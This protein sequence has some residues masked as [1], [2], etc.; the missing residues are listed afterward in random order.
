M[1][2]MSAVLISLSIPVSNALAAGVAPEGG[3]SGFL[4]ECLIGLL[5]LIVLFQF[6]PG[7]ALFGGMVKGIFAPDKE[8]AHEGS[9]SEQ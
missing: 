7:I 5:V 3:G 9:A 6:I 2:A 1:K 4:M 8:A